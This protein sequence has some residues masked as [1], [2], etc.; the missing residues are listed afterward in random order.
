MVFLLLNVKFC[1]T[2][3]V[4]LQFCTIKSIGLVVL[5]TATVR[6]FLCQ[7]TGKR[8][9]AMLTNSCGTTHGAEFFACFGKEVARFVVALG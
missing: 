2:W 4:F 9:T 1:T 8:A 3:C 5:W 7:E 6:A